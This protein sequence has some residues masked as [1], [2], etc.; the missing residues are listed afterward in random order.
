MNACDVL[1]YHPLFFNSSIKIA[2]AFLKRSAY[3]ILTSPRIRTP[4]PGPGKGC[5]LIIDF[6]RPSA[7][8]SFLTSSLNNSLRGSSNFKLSVSG[9]PPTL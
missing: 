8:P 6:G 3:S 2:S 5:L 4:S 7:I 9:S 1:S